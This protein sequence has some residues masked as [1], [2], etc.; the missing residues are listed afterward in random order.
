MI[1]IFDAN[2]P[3]NFRKLSSRLGFLFIGCFL[4][5]LMTSCALIIFRAIIGRTLSL[6]LGIT[7][8]SAVGI[9]IAEVIRQQW[10]PK[11]KLLK[12]WGELKKSQGRLLEGSFLGK[13]SQ[14]T[15]HLGLTFL[16]MT[17]QTDS[18]SKPILAEVYVWSST[19]SPLPPIGSKVRCLLSENV[20]MGYE[21][22]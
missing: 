12:T 14:A 22:C 8:T 17:L 4:G 18:L 15:T 11:K 20:L 7:L 16:V 9:F 6:I 13:A 5:W 21:L 3:E 1:Q 10:Y 2:L 19:P